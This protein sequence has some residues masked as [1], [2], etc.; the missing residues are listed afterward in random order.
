MAQARYLVFALPISVVLTAVQRQRQDLCQA[1]DTSLQQAPEAD[2][3]HKS[4]S[5]K[6]L[7]RRVGGG[8]EKLCFLTH[9]M[10]MLNHICFQK[11][12]SNCMA[13]YKVRYLHE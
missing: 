10:Y 8:G 1:G 3:T 7:P 4:L 5:I 13:L 11:K 9:S 2:K 6:H 12:T